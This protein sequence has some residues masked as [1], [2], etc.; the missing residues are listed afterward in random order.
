MNLRIKNNAGA[1]HLAASRGY[2]EIVQELLDA[3]IAPDMQAKVYA[4]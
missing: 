3:G 2:D 4:Y 1:L